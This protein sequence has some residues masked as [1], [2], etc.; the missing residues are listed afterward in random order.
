MLSH[1]QWRCEDK[2]GPHRTISTRMRTGRPDRRLRL[3]QC[4]RR[5][6][7]CRESPHADGDLRICWLYDGIF[8]AVA[9][10]LRRDEPHGHSPVFG[11]P[12]VAA[13]FFQVAADFRFGRARSRFLAR[14]GIRRVRPAS[15][16]GGRPGSDC[17]PPVP[18][19]LAAARPRRCPVT[20]IARHPGRG[21]LPD[22][23]EVRRHP[24][25]QAPRATPTPPARRKDAPRD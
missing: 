15:R 8:T 17:A 9:C 18:H 20:P 2:F 14:R 12:A 4:R 1:S 13:V 25:R 3:K 6:D 7:L 10:A 24:A 5:A 21:G 16:A 23:V 19:R 11:A 22:I